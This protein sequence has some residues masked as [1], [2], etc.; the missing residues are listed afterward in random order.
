MGLTDEDSARRTFH[1]V[2]E[3]KILRE[4]KRLEEKIDV[5]SFQDL[6][7]ATELATMSVCTMQRDL[8]C[9]TKFVRGEDTQARSRR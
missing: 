6:T 5:D 7:N 9:W 4:C 3:F 2:T 1:I 8:P